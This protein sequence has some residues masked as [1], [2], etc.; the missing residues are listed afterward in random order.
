MKKLDPLSEIRPNTFKDASCIANKKDNAFLIRHYEEFVDVHCPA[1]NGH[2]KCLKFTK[3]SFEYFECVTCETLFISPRPHE[4]LLK[5]LYSESEVYK[6]WSKFIYPA[7]EKQRRTRIYEPRKDQVK[8]LVAQHNLKGNNFLEIGAGY[9]SF[10]EIV[11]S[12]K[13][14]KNVVA[15]EGNDSLLVKCEEKGLNTISGILDAEGYGRLR[16]A[17]DSFGIITAYEILEHVF[18][19]SDFIGRVKA[20]LQ[21]N[22]LVIMTM[23]NI[24]GLDLATLLDKSENIDHEHL[25][26]FNTKSIKLLVESCGLEVLSIST[27]GVLDVSIL[28]SEY[29]KNKS[30]LNNSQ[31][32]KFFFDLNDLQLEQEF[33][34]LIRRNNLSSNMEIIAKNTNK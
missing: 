23:P 26:Y 13:L 30:I 29:N 24:K 6:Y 17:Y 22:G 21:P 1:C 31:F 34:D 15:M 10:S 11:S 18:S 12:A 3:N 2:E 25:N 8:S 32:L 14:F 16:S 28:K 27:P 7:V 4:A 33:Q 5:Q 19:P 9:G 20:L